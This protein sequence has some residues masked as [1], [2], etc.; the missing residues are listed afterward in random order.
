MRIINALLLVAAAA[1]AAASAVRDVQ[2]PSPLKGTPVFTADEVKKCTRIRTPYVET[3]GVSVFHLFAICCGDNACGHKT[4]AGQLVRGTNGTNGTLGDDHK[5]AR[6]IMKTS[7]DNGAT[8]DH[9][10]Y[11]TEQGYANARRKSRGGGADIGERRFCFL[12]GSAGVSSP[13]K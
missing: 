13:H 7:H 12:W 3:S 6:V 10:Q 5:D 4:V 8:W 2:D 11:L 9:T 1:A